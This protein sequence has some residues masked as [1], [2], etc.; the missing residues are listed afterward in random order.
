MASG[1]KTGR[2]QVQREQMLFLFLFFLPDNSKLKTVT[3]PG[4]G[5]DKPAIT[6]DQVPIARLL[7]VAEYK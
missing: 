7:T 6:W 4:S 3:L 1:R 2:Q 5:E